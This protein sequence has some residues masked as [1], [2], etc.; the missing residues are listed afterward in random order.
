[1]YY[2]IKSLYYFYTRVYRQGRSAYSQK[3]ADY[4]FE[5]YIAPYIGTRDI[6]KITPSEFQM[7]LNTLTG[8]SHT[9]ISIIY[10]DLCLIIRRA[11]ID[12]LTD[13][14]PSGLLD[15]PKSKQSTPRRAL[16]PMEREAVIT[17]AQEDSR[18]YPFLF[19]ILCG[20][21]PSEAYA[22]QME[23]I[24]FDRETVHIRGTKTKSAD[25]VVPL[26]SV[27]STL[28][29]KSLTDENR[30]SKIGQKVTKEGQRG[31]WRSFW[32]DCHRYLGGRF[33]RNKP[34]EP[35]PFGTDLTAYNLRHEY[36]TNLA[37]NGV[38]I[39]VTQRLMGHSSPEMTLKVYTNLSN[40]DICTD[41]VRRIVNN[42][43]SCFP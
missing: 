38:D 33:Y 15:K 21:R 22:I 7:V 6:R 35:Y 20:C 25:R 5:R 29:K 1:M 42:L 9:C 2:D 27:I 34:A 17:V 23:D 31:N 14:D 18:Y 19:M 37:R 13:R 41:Q 28:L 24:D 36:C 12:G 26:P 40:D 43:Q 3:C 11:Y 32:K 8:K 10:G 16:T 30:A 4:Y 39:R